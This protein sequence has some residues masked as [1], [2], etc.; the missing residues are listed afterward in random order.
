MTIKMLLAAVGTLA[1]LSTGAA[2]AQTKAK[3]ERTA[4]SLACSK[5]A[6]GKNLHG[7]PRKKFMSQ[8]KKA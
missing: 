2:Y 4:K 8:C 7:K 3:P 6:D 1:M 5:E